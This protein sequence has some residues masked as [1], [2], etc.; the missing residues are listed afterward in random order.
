MILFI[1]DVRLFFLFFFKQ[2]TAYEMRI[3]D[4]S[5]DVCSSYLA[6]DDRFGPRLEHALNVVLSQSRPPQNLRRLIIAAIRR[7]ERA[8]AGAATRLIEADMV[9]TRASNDCTSR[10]VSA[11]RI[12]HAVKPPNP[13]AQSA[14]RALAGRTHSSEE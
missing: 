1:D 12:R 8:G 4:W 3:S 14:R 5:S 7:A 10:S 13:H 6:D 11:T 9:A 2:K